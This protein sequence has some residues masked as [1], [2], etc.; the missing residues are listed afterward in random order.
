MSTYAH[1]LAQPIEWFKLLPSHRK[2]PEFL[3]DGSIGR[4]IAPP[5]PS[6]TRSCPDENADLSSHQTQQ[7][8]AL[9]NPT[10]QQELGAFAPNTAILFSIQVGPT[11]ARAAL[12]SRRCHV[13]PRSIPSSSLW[14]VASPRF[15]PMVSQSHLFA[16]QARSSHHSDYSLWKN[17]CRF[18]RHPAY[19]G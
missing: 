11:L 15:G 5:R 4:H 9:V 14:Q 6:S 8:L 12:I 2:T 3:N 7:H 17:H 1:Q 13:P 16:D 18:R 10:T 19:F